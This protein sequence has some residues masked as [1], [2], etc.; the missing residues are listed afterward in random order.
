M[1]YDSDISINYDPLNGQLKGENLGVV[2]MR[3]LDVQPNP[4]QSSSTLDK[5]LIEILDPT[6]PTNQA[7]SLRNC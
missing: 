2:A 1:V 3:I 4:G 6:D 7:S 5:V